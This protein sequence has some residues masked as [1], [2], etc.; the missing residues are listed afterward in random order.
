M[1]SKL[2]FLALVSVFQC[3]ISGGTSAGWSQSKLPYNSIVDIVGAACSVSSS[4]TCAIVGNQVNSIDITCA[5]PFY[6]CYSKFRFP[7][8]QISIP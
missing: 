5:I 8:R 3:N 7:I 6:I 1:I 4:K 2:I